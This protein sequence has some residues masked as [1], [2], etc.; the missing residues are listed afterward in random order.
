MA[1]ARY[2]RPEHLARPD[3]LVGAVGVLEIVVGQHLLGE[4]RPVG[5]RVA[6]LQ[7]RDRR[8]AADHVGQGVLRPGRP[9]LG[10]RHRGLEA[11]TAAGQARPDPRCLHIGDGRRLQ[12]GGH[13][14][15]DRAERLVGRRIQILR[16][17]TGVARRTGQRRPVRAVPVLPGHQVGQRFR[18]GRRLDPR[19]VGRDPAGGQQ[20][21]RRHRA[22][23][24][25]LQVRSRLAERLGAAEVER[26]TG[27]R[28]HPERVDR[29]GEVGRGTLD[30]GQVGQEP[31][32]D[33]GWARVSPGCY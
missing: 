22:D 17:G 2:E 24:A 33:D 5:P 20:I 16:I 29:T 27:L 1:S 12:I 31:T 30:D 8:R 26:G 18:R 25:E 14:H 15:R 3:R 13:R 23:E 28:L 7:R 32:G 4:E 19:G 21:L 11:V 10:P 9:A 6:Q